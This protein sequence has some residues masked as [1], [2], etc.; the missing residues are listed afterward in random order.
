MSRVREAQDWLLTQ[1]F[2]PALLRQGARLFPTLQTGVMR[3][4]APEVGVEKE[5]KAADKQNKETDSVERLAVDMRYWGNRKPT[6][7]LFSI[8]NRRGQITPGTRITSIKS[9]KC[10]DFV[11]KH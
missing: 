8:G 7:R 2:S 11:K 9:S 1:P 4:S 6:T 5:A 3:G 10:S